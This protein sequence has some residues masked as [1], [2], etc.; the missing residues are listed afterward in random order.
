MNRITPPTHPLERLF[1]I[2]ST[3]EKYFLL[4]RKLAEKVNLSLP[5]LRQYLHIMV[6][7]GLLVEEQTETRTRYI[8][9]SRGQRFCLWYRRLQHELGCEKSA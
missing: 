1:L 7:K 5:Q 2:L 4:S 8:V 3:S 9:T 6:T